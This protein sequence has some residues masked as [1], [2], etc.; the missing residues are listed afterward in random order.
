MLCVGICRNLMAKESVLLQ[1]EFLQHQLVTTLCEKKL[2]S[3]VCSKLAVDKLMTAN[4][5]RFKSGSTQIALGLGQKDVKEDDR[6][7]KEYFCLYAADYCGELIRI[8]CRWLFGSLA[9]ELKF[10]VFGGLYWINA[11]FQGT[12]GGPGPVVVQ[13]FLWRAHMLI[14]VQ[15]CIHV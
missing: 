12:S 15:S 2:T 4:S 14:C 7:C 1:A 13:T 10:V 5:A 6:L 8:K 11:L 9:T 3:F